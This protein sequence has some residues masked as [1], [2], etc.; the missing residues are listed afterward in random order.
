MSDLLLTS[1][2]N[3]EGYAIKKY[4]GICSG[5]F[6][7][8]TGWLSSLEAGLSDLFGVGSDLYAGKLRQA[9]EAALENLERF[10]K[11]LGANAVIGVDIDYNVFSADLIAVSANGTAVYIEPVLQEEQEIIRKKCFVSD[12][13]LSMPIYPVS[14]EVVANKNGT[15]V[16]LSFLSKDM[17][18]KTLSAD[19]T[20]STI[21]EKKTDPVNLKFL[22]IEY[23]K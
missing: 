18:T 11:K 17:L 1:G 19:I 16:K 22:K 3:F 5:E 7:L 8:G 14:L 2:Y 20:F 21:F 12:Y 15:K 4:L 23:K 6:V 10:A 9:K 13:N